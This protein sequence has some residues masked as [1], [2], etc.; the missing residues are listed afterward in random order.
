MR[1]GDGAALAPHVGIILQRLGDRDPYVRQAALE[2]AKLTVL[3][4]TCL[5]SFTSF[6]ADLLSGVTN[7][8]AFIGLWRSERSDF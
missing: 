7:T 5:T 1:L 8:L 6:A 3:F 4:L 2:G